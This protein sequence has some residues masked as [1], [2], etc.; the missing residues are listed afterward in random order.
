M[1]TYVV[2]R[3]GSGCASSPKRRPGSRRPLAAIPPRISAS[4]STRRTATSSSTTTPPARSGRSP[5][6][7]TP[8]S[9]PR[10]L[11]DGKRISLHARRQSLRDVARSRLARADDRYRARPAP[12]RA[13]A[14]AGG[15]WRRQA[16]GG[17]G[18]RGRADRRAAARHRQ[19]GVSQEGAEGTAGGHPRAR[20]PPRGGRGPAQ[21]RESAQALHPA[22]APVRRVAA[23]LAGRE[24]RH[25]RRS[26]KRAATAKNT[27]VPNF[28]TESAYT[29]DIS[30]PLQRGR[31]ASPP[32]GWR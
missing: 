9:N 2:N 18:G 24:I 20:R 28:V 12:R 16:R 3:D 15:A 30:R 21:A 10:F 14:A 17:R 27:I 26:R 1:D 7:P 13:G 25:R 11:R 8:K 29:E 32:R 5:R 23:A 19:P 4:R 6:P 22:G 31:Y